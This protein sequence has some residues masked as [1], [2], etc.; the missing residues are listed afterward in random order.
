MKKID[1]K[2]D[3][4]IHKLLLSY[5]KYLMG[6]LVCL[7]SMSLILFIQPL[8]IQKI[9]DFGM[10]KKN[11]RVILTNASLLLIISLLYQM[12]DTM[13]TR[14]FSNIYN[15]VSF[16]LYQQAYRKMNKL[17]IEYYSEN[18][19]AEIVHAVSNDI[20][21]IASVANQMTSFSVTSILQIVG[22]VMGLAVLNWKM[23]VLIV[24]L[25]PIKFMV[26]YF[27][28]KKKNNATERM[29]KNNHK[30]F[31]WMG[32]CING[33]YDMKLWN[34]FQIKYVEFERL[35]KS[36]MNSYY[37]NR[38]LDKYKNV[39]ISFLD[40]TLNSMIYILSGLMIVAG[41][42]TIGSAFAFITYVGY[43]VNPISFL[44]DIKYYFAEIKPSIKRFDNFM[45]LPE[46]QDETLTTIL[47]RDKE[48]LPCANREKG[49]VE[50]PILELCG[51]Q[52]GYKTGNSVLKNI[53]L[54]VYPG[55]KI[56]IIGENG[57]GKSTLLNLLSGFYQPDRGCIKIQ[58]IPV[59]KF[60]IKNLREKISMVC[61]KP[62]LFKGTIE[63]NININGKV[64]H[65]EVIDCCK[66]SGAIDFIE[67]L[68]NK[69]DQFVGQNGAKL[70]GGEKQKLAVARALTKKADILILDEATSGFDKESNKE[71]IDLI[72]KELK[73]QTIICVTHRYEELESI[74]KVYK[75][76]KGELKLVM[77]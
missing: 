75:L 62:Y 48:E 52:F 54:I 21:N 77:K 57:S 53:N 20:D 15:G 65:D 16:S 66:K 13:Q 1:F 50:T 9:T 12:F 3:K 32:D 2:I 23:T 38:M 68:E 26:V 6:I 72:C 55:E 56:A 76:S 40:A 22:G 59:S 10:V 67:Q 74:Q 8:I 27:F 33:I 42:F 7:I 28:S 60:G 35:Q 24:L 49:N 44:I 58:G 51:I 19:S 4:S 31:S 25:I 61:Q 30:F 45:E 41:N 5:K 71:M 34:L 29:I 37:E 43:V 69:F 70:S 36:I 46:E 73:E 47:R 63:E 17:R 64:S 39:S 18:G 11:M 14:F